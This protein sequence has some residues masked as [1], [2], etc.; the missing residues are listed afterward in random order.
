MESTS[1]SLKKTPLKA[2]WDKKLRLIKKF[3][4]G[5][6]ELTLM[7]RNIYLSRSLDDAEINMKKQA[8]AFFQISGAG[9]EGI[10]TGMGMVLRPSHDWFFPITGIVPFVS[11]WV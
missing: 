7:W 6:K 2:V 10:L 3:G 8:K 5:K 4:L 1:L 9:H 11:L